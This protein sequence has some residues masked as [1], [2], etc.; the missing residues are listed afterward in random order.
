MYYFHWTHLPIR[1]F[2]GH[3]VKCHVSWESL[4]IIHSDL[5]LLYSVFTSHRTI[6]GQS[7]QTIYC[8]T[9]NNKSNRHI[10]I[11]MVPL[12]RTLVPCLKRDNL[13]QVWPFQPLSV[14]SSRHR[15]P[16]NDRVQKNWQ[17]Y[18]YVSIYGNMSHIDM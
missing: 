7:R 5:E 16:F 14:R 8:I 1:N 6:A 10:T 3:T 15:L 9:D 17:S 18:M 2:L 12:F 13:C 4:R 11:Y